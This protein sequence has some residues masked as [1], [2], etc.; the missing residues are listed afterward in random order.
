MFTVI[1][2]AFTVTNI[3]KKEIIIWAWERK[4]NFAFLNNPEF[5]NYNFTIAFY[6]LGIEFKEGKFKS[7]K[8]LNQIN[9]PN[10][11]NKIPVIRVD[12]Y[13]KPISEPDDKRIKLLVDL[14]I[15]TCTKYNTKECQ[16]D[17]DIRQSEI[18]S[19]KEIL[20]EVKQRLPEGMK[21]SITVLVSWC[22]LGSWVDQTSVDYAVPMFYDLGSD[23]RKIMT[24][25]VDSNFLKAE[26]CKAFIGVSKDDSIPSYFG[27]KSKNLYLWSNN[28]WS[29]E[30][31]AEILK[32]IYH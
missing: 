26:K 16:V 18:E 27:I 13:D 12:N 31:L 25:D 8:R 2:L 21:L 17:F 28:S 30:N 5:N 3:K 6:A 23:K 4:E 9:F 10:N 7:T 11:I 24:G 32:K 20:S 29:R 1:I 22:R 19:Y 15:E 14:I